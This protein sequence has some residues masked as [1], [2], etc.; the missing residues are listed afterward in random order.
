MVSYLDLS[1]EFVVLVV[2]RVREFI[3]FYFVFLYLF[4]YLM[5]EESN[6]NEGNKYIL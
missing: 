1:D 3:D 6:E 5:K 4:H 2:L